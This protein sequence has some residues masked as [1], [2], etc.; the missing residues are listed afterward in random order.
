[1]NDQWLP[2]LPSPPQPASN[3]FP[4]GNTWNSVAGCSVSPDQP[5]FVYGVVITGIPAAIGA[6]YAWSITLNDGANPPNFSIDHYDASGNLIDHPLTFSGVDGSA[7]FNDP[8]TAVSLAITTGQLYVPS[9]D[10]LTIPGGPIGSYLGSAGGGSLAWFNLPAPPIPTDAPSDGN[11]YGRTNGG[12]SSGGI[13]TQPLYINGA[14]SLALVGPNQTQRSI[15]AGTGTP[16]SA[17]WRWQLVLADQTSESGGNT[18]SNFA[19]NALADSGNLMPGP[20]ALAI[21]RANNAAVFGGTITAPGQPGNAPAITINKTNTGFVNAIAGQTNGVM[22]WQ[23]SL[24]DPS[25]ELGSNFG[26]NFVIQRYQDSGAGFPLPLPFTIN[27]STGNAVFGYGLTVTGVLTLATPANLSI[28][29]GSPDQVLITDGAGNL[30]WADQSGGGGGG[31]IGEAPV[32]GTSYARNDATWVHLSSADITDWAA[33]LANYYPTSNPAGYQTAAQ[34]TAALGGYLPLIGGILTG[35]LGLNGTAANRAIVGQTNG[36][37]RW[38]AY[39]GDTTAEVGGATGSNFVL[40]SYADNGATLATPLSITRQGVATFSQLPSFPGGSSGQV[41]STNGAGALSWASV[42]A[43]QGPPVTIS[44]TAPANPVA[45]ALWWDSVGGQLYVYFTDLTSSQW[46]VAVNAASA[47]PIASTTTLG[48]VKVDGT[49]I[50]AATDGT[51]STVLVPMGDNRIINGDMRIDQRNGG[52]SGTATNVYTV[53]RWGFGASETGKGTWQRI[54]TSLGWFPYALSFTSSSAYALLA[55]DYFQFS[56]SLEADAVSD[57]AWGTSNAQPVTL[58]FWAFSSLTGTLSGSI[59][60]YVGSRAYPFTFN[61]PTANTWT[62]ISI[63]I[64]GDTAGSWVMSGNGGAVIVHFDLGT[65]A[66]YRAPAGAWAGGNFIG[67]NG[68]QSIVA[69]NGAQLQITGVKLEI[70]GIATPFNR[71]LLAKSMADCQRYY[72]AGNVQLWGYALASNGLASI[73][74]FPVV[75]RASPTITPNFTTQLNCTAGMNAM[76]NAFYQVLTT[77]VP[78]NG[79]VNLAGTFIASAEL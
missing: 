24:G 72:Q 14:N 65:G 20:S 22:R 44:D 49:S 37:N 11:L 63:T 59:S 69:T 73:Y 64:P 56:T 7:R 39:Y 62:K 41:L 30:S 21:T 50:K 1:M 10:Q 27:R 42:S 48:G 70:G 79:T 15:M 35:P 53:D 31:G 9:A 5:S 75:M 45:G 29:G 74:P 6:P 17:S 55:N 40:Q 34:V 18:G 12:W 60:N 32:D 71:Q 16:A 57:F 26:S 38:V 28:S 47:L 58:A 76:N 54:A 66:T 46:V 78:A 25:A 8:V 23:I 19:L 61:I 33:Q 2:S 52:A 36:I 4:P 43:P 13:F 68:A 51:I 77:N 67:A 3:P